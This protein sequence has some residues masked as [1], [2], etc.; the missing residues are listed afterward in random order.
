MIVGVTQF[1]L[2]VIEIEEYIY[3]HQS[4]LFILLKAAGPVA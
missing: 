1:L 4:I 2:F 3:Q